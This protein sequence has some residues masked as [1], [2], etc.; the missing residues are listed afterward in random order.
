MVVVKKNADGTNKIIEKGKRCLTPT[1]YPFWKRIPDIS[2]STISTRSQEQKQKIASRGEYNRYLRQ[3]GRDNIKRWLEAYDSDVY[4]M[5]ESDTF[6]VV[7]PEID[8]NVNV[9]E[10]RKILHYF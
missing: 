7:S 4:V 10:L 9:K 6:F 5:K 1:S 2:T 3:N 8:S